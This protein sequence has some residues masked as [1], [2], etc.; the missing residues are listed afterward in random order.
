MRQEE[1][2]RALSELVQ[3]VRARNVCVA[4]VCCLATSYH[5]ACVLMDAVCLFPVNP[6]RV[7]CVRAVAL[8]CAA[9]L[10]H[11]HTHG[12]TIVL[13]NTNNSCFTAQDEMSSNSQK[14][15]ELLQ[16]M[17][18]QQDALSRRVE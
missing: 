18:A 6:H 12:V 3:G 10:T 14:M 1:Q 9:C 16:A 7:L 8:Y 4:C 15:V 5:L 2:Q 17:Q 13:I 11:Q